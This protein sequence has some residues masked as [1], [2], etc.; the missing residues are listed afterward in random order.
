METKL[1]FF[2]QTSDLIPHIVYTMSKLNFSFHT[3][4][5]RHTYM[6]SCHFYSS[7][8][9][10]IGEQTQA[11][12]LRVR[13][14]CKA[15]HSKRGLWGMEGL[16]NPL[17]QFIICYRTPKGRLRVG[18]RLQ[19]WREEMLYEQLNTKQSERHE[20]TPWQQTGSGSHC[21]SIYTGLNRLD[22]IF[23]VSYKIYFHISHQIHNF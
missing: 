13:W 2:I 9:V 7:I 12:P 23:S 14:V 11:E 20:H 17:V 22:Q 21:V 6:P 5:T 3:K 16:S 8:S 10:N 15:V 4:K 19:I 18:N 1:G